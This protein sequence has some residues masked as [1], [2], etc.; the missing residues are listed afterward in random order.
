MCNRRYFQHFHFIPL[1]GMG[2]RGVY[3]LV[4]DDL[5]RQNPFG[6]TLKFTGPVPADSRQ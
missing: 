2:K 5:L 1:V 6:T 3:L 4:H